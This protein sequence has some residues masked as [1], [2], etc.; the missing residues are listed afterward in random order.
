MLM[1]AWTTVGKKEDAERLA[2]GMVERCLAACVQIEGPVRSV[3]S[4]EGKVESAEEYRLLVKFIPA[5]GRTLEA[6]VLANHPYTT[7]EWLVVRAEHVAEKYLSWARANS[8]SA[9]L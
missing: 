9:P 8:T 3:Y 6:W 2:H 4:W 5:R 7:P 1:L